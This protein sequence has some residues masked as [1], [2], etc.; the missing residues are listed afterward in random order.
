MPS[1][2]VLLETDTIFVIG[3]NRSRAQASMFKGTCRQNAGRVRS[4]AEAGAP[5]GS[6]IAD[7]VRRDR[8]RPRVV[9]GIAQTV[10]RAALRVRFE[11][12]TIDL[13]PEAMQLVLE[14]A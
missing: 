10:L 8:P 3:R 14:G 5:I 12:L 11:A 7:P 9:Q 2:G 13:F 1:P 6:A 4:G